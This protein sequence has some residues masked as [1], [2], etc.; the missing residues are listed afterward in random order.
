VEVVAI[1]L[2]LIFVFQWFQWPSSKQAQ[3]PEPTP[4][5]T[6]PEPPP[7]SE[8]VRLLLDEEPLAQENSMTVSELVEAILDKPEAIPAGTAEPIIPSPEVAVT[9]GEVISDTVV[10]LIPVG[11]VEAIASEPSLSFVEPPSAIPAP[12]PQNPSRPTSRRDEVWA[13]LDEATAEGVQGYDALMAY[14]KEKSGK[15]T[16]RST[17]KA[18]KEARAE[19]VCG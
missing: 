8:R 16:S 12:V 1:T 3:T 4:L 10:E 15:G 18:W 11:T 5:I 14:V 7:S 19:V 2:L 17:V 13:L 6:A 9:P